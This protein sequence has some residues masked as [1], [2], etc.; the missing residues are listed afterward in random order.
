MNGCTNERAHHRFIIVVVSSIDQPEMNVLTIYDVRNKFIAYSCPLPKIFAVFTEWGSL[1]VVCWNYKVVIT[2]FWRWWKAW[3]KG[4]IWKID[5]KEQW[6][7]GIIKGSLLI[8]TKN[9]FIINL[10]LTKSC[11][12]DLLQIHLSTL[13]QIYH[14]QE[15][16]IQSKLDL[17]FKKNLYDVAIRWV[18]R[19]WLVYVFFICIIFS[20]S[21]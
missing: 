8:I 13:T 9:K 14:L 11:V 18:P 21:S 12:G 16:G 3:K 4:N 19:F 10:F 2:S 15:M 5:N 6:L 1:Y 20:T 17:L 7:A